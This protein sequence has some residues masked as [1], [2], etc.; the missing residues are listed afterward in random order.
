MSTNEDSME[1]VAVV[2]MTEDRII[3]TE[4]GVPWDHPED[5]KQY[6]N[7]VAKS[8]VIVG[9]TTYES[10]LPDPPGDRHIVLSR[11]LNETDAPTATVAHTVRDALLAAEKIGAKT[12]YVIGGGQIYDALLE[13]YDRMIITVVE[14]EINPQEHD[15]I[16]KYPSWPASKWKKTRTKDSYE[17]FRIDFWN[18]TTSE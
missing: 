1:L 12:T 13:E 5:V 18:S 11:T 14:D 16:I 15:R 8:P 3:A 17:G 6:K 10:M 7:R 4:D 2:A 9:R